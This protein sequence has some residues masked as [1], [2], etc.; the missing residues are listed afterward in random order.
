LKGQIDKILELQ[1]KNGL[2]AFLHNPYMWVEHF[3]GT[4]TK[5]DWKCNPFAFI[6]IGP[7]GDVRSCGSAFGNINKRSLSECLT[8][9]EA[10]EAREIMKACQKPCM[11]TCWAHPESDSLR[12][13]V[14]V[15]F[16]KLKKD[17]KRNQKKN[18]KKGLE[19]LSEYGQALKQYAQ[20]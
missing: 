16:S 19:L 13:I 9:P 14:N 20:A 10:N 7:D 3:K 17:S 11:Q 8:T 5:K 12:N 15:F 1:A 4:L 6:N 18:M 2:V